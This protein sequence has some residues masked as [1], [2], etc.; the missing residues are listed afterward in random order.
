LDEAYPRAF[1]L[2]EFLQT[3]LGR[4]ATGVTVALVLELLL[5]LA[6]LS[7]S[8]SANP[9][10]ESQLTTFSAENY[11]QP[12]P[13]PELQPQPQPSR[14]QPTPQ[15]NQTVVAPPQ[16]APSPAFVIPTPEAPR[17]PPPAETP[18]PPKPGVRMG[19][20]QGPPN[21][22]APS[23]ASSD[24]QRVGTAPNGEPLYAARWYREPGDEVRGF[25][26]DSSPGSGLIA[27]RTIPNFYVTD[28]VA[29][30][31]TQ[32][33]NIIRAMLAASGNFRVRPAQIGGRSLVGSWVRIRFDYT[34]VRR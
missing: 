2:P 33:S 25:F 1:S 7:L 21:S 22:P 15:P 27:C 23:S 14:D 20:P 8:R 30:G 32:G 31:E 18:T 6:L 9:P 4:R 10:Q 28:C 3:E 13:E 29:I 17:V 24:S 26:A 5:L 11:S 12:A 34:I 16:P 19:P